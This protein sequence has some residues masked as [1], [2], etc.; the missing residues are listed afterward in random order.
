M[1]SDSGVTPNQVDHTH[2]CV[3][4]LCGVGDLSETP[5]RLKCCTV[6]KL[7]DA[8]A[9]LHGDPLKCSI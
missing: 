9:Y 6:L 1:Q 4:A 3:V 5:C 7:L 8:V 2:L